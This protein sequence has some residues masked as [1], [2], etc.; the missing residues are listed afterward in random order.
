MRNVKISL[1]RREYKLT[2]KGLKNQSDSR[3]YKK[4]IKNE[5]PSTYNL[6]LV[7]IFI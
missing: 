7:V 3:F 2:V 1:A 5:L 6:H 4:K